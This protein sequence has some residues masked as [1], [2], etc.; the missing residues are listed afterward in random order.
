MWWNFNLSLD[1]SC[2]MTSHLTNWTQHEAECDPGP[3]PTVFKNTT[4]A[5]KVKHVSA[6]QLWTK[7]RIRKRTYVNPGAATRWI[8]SCSLT[9]LNSRRSRESFRKADHTHVICILFQTAAALVTAV[10]TWQT[11]IL[12]LYSSAGVSTRVGLTACQF[13]IFLTE[14]EGKSLSGRPRFLY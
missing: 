9:N 5:L 7:Q 6:I 11:R 4:S 3:Q 8:D 2:L 13:G 10:K 1:G 14:K 12:I